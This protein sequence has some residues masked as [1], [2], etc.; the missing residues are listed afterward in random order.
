MVA[1]ATIGS[2]LEFSLF[3]SERKLKRSGGSHF[4][5]AGY[6][7]ERFLITWVIPPKW[8]ALWKTFGFKKLSICA[9]QNRTS[10]KNASP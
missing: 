4:V 5:T 1:T 8:K 7:L 10:S 9:L 2:F 6:D 3:Q